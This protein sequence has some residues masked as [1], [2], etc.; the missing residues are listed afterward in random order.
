MTSSP[1]EQV[2]TAGGGGVNDKWT[3]IRAAKLGVPVKRAA[4][5]QAAYGSALLARGSTA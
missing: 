3:D 1:W 5:W 2:M 4:Q